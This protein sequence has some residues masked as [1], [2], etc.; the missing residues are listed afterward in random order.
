MHHGTWVMR[1]PWCMSESPTS[2]LLWS[3]WRGKCSRRMRN[4]QFYVSGK[5]RIAKHL[6]RN[7]PDAHLR[8]T[9]ERIKRVFVKFHHNAI[10]SLW[11]RDAIW[12]HR[13]GATLP[14]VMAC[15]LIITWTNVDLSTVRS[16]ES[17]M[18]AISQEIPH[19]LITKIGLKISI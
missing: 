5:R 13:S 6:G 17:H 14:Q 4:P 15:C 9:E 19:Q 3:Q 18:R 8:C 12:W 7:G 10:I 16:I 2:G 1:A 11:P